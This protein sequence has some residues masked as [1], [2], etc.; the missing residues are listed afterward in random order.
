MPAPDPSVRFV[1]IVCFRAAATEPGTCAR[2]GVPL[3]PVADAEVLAALQA[4][5][6]RRANRRE[7]VR[8]GLALATGAAIALPLCLAMG[9]QILPRAADGLYSG[10]FAWVALLAAIALGA[11]SLPIIRPL[12]TDGDA[13]QLLARL[14]LDRPRQP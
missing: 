2:D 14:G 5:V 12:S 6:R 7:G 3:A 10:T 11:L 13:A 4:R 8:F 1:C 9:W